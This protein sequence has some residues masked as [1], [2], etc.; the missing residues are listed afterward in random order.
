LEPSWEFELEAYRCGYRW[1]AGIDEAG[2][3]P[4]AGP[5][6]AAA[7][8]L[9]RCCRLPGLN[10]SKQLP[11]PQRARLYDVILGRAVG[12]GV[13]VASAQEIDASNIVEATRLAMGRAI[14]ALNPRPHR[15][16]VDALTLPSISLPQRPIVKGDTLSMSVAAASIVAKVTRD[17]L[18]ADYHKIY[19]AYNFIAHK[20]YP[21]SEHL[22]LL[23]RHGPC[24]LHRRTF[25]PV[26]ES[27]ARQAPKVSRC[28]V[29]QG[30][31][32]EK[33]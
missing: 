28:G 3:G 20:G 11:E 13:G 12:V 18:M 19:P 29:A 16:L 4:L 30:H 1:V 24:M 22:Y 27:T 6:V 17:R 5:V 26:L 15:L 33:P 23:D 21:T 10:D 8:I 25:R 31:C 14:Q 7:V 32:Q 2:R 9:P